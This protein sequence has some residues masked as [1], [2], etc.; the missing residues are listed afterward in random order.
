MSEKNESPRS[1][2]Q[3]HAVWIIPVVAVLFVVVFGIFVRLAI[4]PT[5][6][7]KIDYGTTNFVPGESPHST[8]PDSR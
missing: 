7:Q 4:G 1:K 6:E 3:E 2:L 8:G 5:D